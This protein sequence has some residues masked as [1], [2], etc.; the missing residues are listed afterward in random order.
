[1]TIQEF[2]PSAIDLCV[3]DAS[4]KVFARIRFDE[5]ENLRLRR[6]KPIHPWRRRSTWPPRTIADARGPLGSHLGG[7]HQRQAS[8]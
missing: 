5:A 8:G 6:I 1:M 3:D 7:P 4:Q 2:K